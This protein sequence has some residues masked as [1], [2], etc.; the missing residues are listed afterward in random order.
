MK[1][2]LKVLLGLF[3]YFL[4]A[5]QSYTNTFN[6]EWINFDKSNNRQILKGPIDLFKGSLRDKLNP[7]IPALLYE[8][9]LTS[10][11]KLEIKLSVHQRSIHHTIPGL[12]LHGPRERNQLG[13]SQSPY[14]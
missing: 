10:D 11:G 9:P 8:I 4:F 1:S 13:S 6:F 5:Q 3:P 14:V 12:S 2:I 7:D